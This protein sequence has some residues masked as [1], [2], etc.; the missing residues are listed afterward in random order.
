MSYD[1]RL[2]ELEDLSRI[3]FKWTFEEDEQLLEEVENSKDYDIIALN[4]KRTK[5]GIISRVISKII[6]PKY[7]EIFDNDIIEKDITNISDEF[8]IDADKIIKYINKFKIIINLPQI[9]VNKLSNENKLLQHIK[10]LDTKI[11]A[12]NKKLDRVLTKYEYNW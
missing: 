9:D 5:T 8:N 2:K 7:K 6:Y 3:G 10:S 11:D 1:K 4:H 12:V